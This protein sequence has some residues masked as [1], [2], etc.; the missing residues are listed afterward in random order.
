MS[1][2]H[3]PRPL[4]KPLTTESKEVCAVGECPLSREIQD[5]RRKKS[6]KAP[7]KR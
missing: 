1:N 6:K 5:G 4:A 3:V 2:I 7:L